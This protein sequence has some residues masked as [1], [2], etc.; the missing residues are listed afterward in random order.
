MIHADH[1]VCVAWC[2]LAAMTAKFAAMRHRYGRGGSFKLIFRMST[3]LRRPFGHTTAPSRTAYRN[4]VRG[5]KPSRPAATFRATTSSEWGEAGRSFFPSSI[6]F[7]RSCKRPDRNASSRSSSVSDMVVSSDRVEVPAVRSSN[8]DDVALP[9]RPRQSA[10]RRRSLGSIRPPALAEARSGSAA[11][12]QQI[13]ERRR[14]H[15]AM[16]AQAAPDMPPQVAN[17]RNLD[18]AAR[19]QKS[20]FLRHFRKP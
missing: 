20:R 19:R 6:E 1:H 7:K 18:P 11:P 14:G 12:V 8:Y 10:P 3:C 17:R 4:T 15:H 9:P 16:A 13:G 5:D 2:C